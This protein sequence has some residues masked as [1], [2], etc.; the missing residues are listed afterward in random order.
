MIPIKGKAKARLNNA[1]SIA[2]TEI[3]MIAAHP[4]ADLIEELVASIE[5]AAR[6]IC[7]GRRDTGVGAHIAMGGART[8]PQQGSASVDTP[9]SAFEDDVRGERAQQRGT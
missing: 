3:M 5:I 9:A 8:A 7:Q 2:S 4:L 1:L 6:A